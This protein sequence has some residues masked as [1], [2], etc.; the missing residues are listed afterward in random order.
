MKWI[1]VFAT[2]IAFEVCAKEAQPFA[3]DAVLEKH[4]L[5]L[6]QDLRCLVCQN[7]SLADSHANLAI[8]L[9]AEM[10]D[11]IKAGMSDEEIVNFMVQRY[12][13]FVRFKPALRVS[14]IAL[15]FGP[16]IL[17]VV[18]LVFL[19]VH[20]RQRAKK[21]VGVPLAENDTRRLAE[22]LGADNERR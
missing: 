1:L 17:L 9:R 8:D 16:F 22:L 21:V 6:A 12:G 20:L 18:G 19:F 11:K 4:V 14:T 5:D 3:H 15:W 2:L 10:R 13:E 7:E